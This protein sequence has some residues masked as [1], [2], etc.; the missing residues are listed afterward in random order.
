MGNTLAGGKSCWGLIGGLVVALAAAMA[1]AELQAQTTDVVVAYAFDEGSGPVAGD[2][3]PNANHGTISGATWTTQGRYQSGLSFDGVNDRVTGPSISPGARFTMMAWIFNPS[4]AAYETILTVGSNRDVYLYNG[5]LS[6]YTVN[7][8][9]RFGSA[10]PTNTWQHVAI[11]YDGATLRAYVNATLR[12]TQTVTL[13]STS[14]TLQI[15]AW[16]YG[17]SGAD[18]FSGVIDEVRVYN[19]VLSAAE[20]QTGLDTPISGPAADTTPPT[21]SNG[22]PSGT[23]PAD[24]STATLSLVTDE[25]ATC[26]Y[27][28][29]P[30]TSYAAMLNL[31]ATTGGTTHSTAVVGLTSGTTYTFYVRCQDNVGNANPTDFSIIFSVAST[32]TSPPTVTLSSPAQD[33][34]VSGTVNVSADAFDDRGVVGVQFLL[35]GANLGTEDLSTPFA[36]SWDTTTAS[37]GAHRLQAMARDAAG[38]RATSA[39]INVTVS[40]PQGG[41]F[42]L[43]FTGN[44]SNVNRVDIPLDAP[45]RPVDVGATD[46]TIEWWMKVGPGNVSAATCQSGRDGWIQ[47]DILFDRDVNGPGDY[48]DYGISLS[49]NGLAFGV[50]N[51]TAGGGICGTTNLADDQWHHV[52]VTRRF[53]DGQLQ[54]YVDGRLDAS[55]QGPSGEVSYR[56]NRPTGN[57]QSDP[58]LVIGSEKHNFVP[59]IFRGILDEVRVSTVLRYSST[60]VRPSGPF[61]P[62]TDTAALYHFDD[63]QGDLINDASGAAGGPSQGTR[64]SGGSPAGPIWVTDSPFR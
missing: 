41:Q 63:G 17:T 60:F 6:V 8:D 43:Q 24:S 57:P 45:A 48:G 46:F 39:L 36:T 22:Q 51:Q 28:T 27:A 61:V 58:F 38:N 34:T 21:R 9:F 31:F 49:R 25:S 53:S 33:A 54:L 1:V 55:G 56:D 4:N 11:S 32:D 35:D 42:A 7:R 52:A 23:L 10:L 26:R 50:A 16:I 64:R 14:G 40:N 30:G 59:P 15:G 62:D 2:Q 19:R 47:G 37:A 13:G 12:G 3:S 29:T 20:I 5:V 44:G 18:F